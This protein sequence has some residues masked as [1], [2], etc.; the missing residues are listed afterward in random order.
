MDRGTKQIRALCAI[1]IVE[2]AYRLEGTEAEWLDAVLAAARPDLDTGCGTYAFTGNDAVP[3]FE[4]SPVFV[5]QDLDMGFAARVAELNRDA[6]REVADL[7]RRQ[8]VTCGGLEQT[9]G[10]DSTIFRS[11]RAVVQGT[12]IQ[13]G[14]S[15]FARD[16]QGGSVSM[17]APSRSLV[18]LAPRVRGIWRRVGLHVA[19]SLRLRRKLAAHATVRDALL[20]PSGKVHDATGSVAE[21]ASARSVLVR[22]VA[23]MEKARSGAVRGSPERALSLWQGLVAGEWSLVDHWESGGRR[24]LAAYRNRPELRDPRALT[25]QERATLKYLALGASNKDI[26]FAL[27]LP[28]GTVSSSVTKVMRK[29]GVKRRVDLALFADPSRMDRLDLAVADGDGGGAGEAG[30]LGEL[31]VLRA[32]ARPHGVAAEALSVAELEVTS[33]VARG[34]S[35]ERIANERQVSPRT[36]ANQLR[37]IYDKLGVTSR[38]QLVRVVTTPHAPPPAPRGPQRPREGAR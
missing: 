4:A 35:N 8:L 17:S 1:D 34:W 38:S 11:F 10:A 26:A 19:S 24:Y 3:N 29:L 30:D 5:Q 36:I 13:D 31:G 9:L 28:A 33:Y 20:D 25:P 23:A 6:P 12:G 21:S 16:A 15:L 37:A 18:R 7:L 27:G 32:D 22:A 2:T 14:F